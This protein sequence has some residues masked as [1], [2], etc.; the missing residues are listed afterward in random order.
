MD[1]ET[2][3]HKLCG[4]QVARNTLERIAHDYYTLDPHNPS[5]FVRR[6]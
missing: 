5:S 6:V 3:A 2:V 4:F 1:F